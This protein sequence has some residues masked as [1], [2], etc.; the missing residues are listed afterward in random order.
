MPNTI[1]IEP[2]AQMLRSISLQKRTGLLKVE[3]L[4]EGGVEQGE[5]YFEIGRPMHARVGQEKGKT[6]L[7]RISTWKH[8]TCSFTGMSRPYPGNAP[9]LPGPSEIKKAE[10][11]RSFLPQVSNSPRSP[12]P[13][14]LTQEAYKEDTDPSLLM[15]DVHKTPLP[16][17]TQPGGPVTSTNLR[18]AHSTA[19]SLVVRGN[20]LE[21]YIPAPAQV[22][23]RSVQRW[24]THQQREQ[25]TG[26]FLSKPPATPRPENLP[27]AGPLPGRLAVFKARAMVTTAQ[28]INQMERRERIIFILL[29]GSRTI[30]D[31]ARLTHHTESEVEQILLSLTSR[32][33]TEYIPGPPSVSSV[34]DKMINLF[35][36][37]A[38]EESTVK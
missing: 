13:S 37:S 23:P 11:N 5:I 28:S 26:S 27:N 7:K 10:T 22:A 8:I 18:M 29:D 35:S 31:L 32:G 21:E 30:Q 24:T 9:A 33:Y 1:S 20:T 6:A 15:S 34:H 16:H 2:L 38:Q 14:S 17:S 4:G 3:Q 19:Q 12:L 25:T 36:Q